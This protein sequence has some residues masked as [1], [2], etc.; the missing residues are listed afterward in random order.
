MN[1]DLQRQRQE[2]D[3]LQTVESGSIWLDLTPAQI[4]ALPNPRIYSNHTSLDNAKLNQLCLTKFQAYLDDREMEHSLSFSIDELNTIWD[5]VT[6]CAIQI[7]AMRLILI[8]S[9]NLDQIGRASCR[10]RV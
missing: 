4:D 6:G 7:G 8:P 5:V 10:E 1:I 3:M 9:D 2:L